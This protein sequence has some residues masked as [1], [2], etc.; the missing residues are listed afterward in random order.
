MAKDVGFKERIDVGGFRREVGDLLSV[1]N[2]GFLELVLDGLNYFHGRDRIFGSYIYN[3][4]N[5]V[6]IINII[7]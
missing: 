1:F 4:L 7:I 6:L 5:C 3:E 2:F